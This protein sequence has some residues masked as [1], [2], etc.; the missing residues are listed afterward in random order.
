MVRTTLHLVELVPDNLCLVPMILP[1]DD[2]KPDIA[3]MVFTI[4]PLGDFVHD[5]ARM[6]P[7]MPHLV[8]KMPDLS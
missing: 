6:A 8:D 5:G 2:T 7:T 4:L 3:W 1:F